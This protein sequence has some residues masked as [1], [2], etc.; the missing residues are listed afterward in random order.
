MEQLLEEG[1]PYAEWQLACT[2]LNKVPF[3]VNDAEE[4]FALI[5]SAGSGVHTITSF[6]ARYQDVAPELVL[7][8]LRARFNLVAEAED[9]GVDLKTTN[10]NIY[11]KMLTG[12]LTPEDFSIF[13]AFVDAED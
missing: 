2:A 5:R 8:S 9:C 3:T 4:G 6:A 11:R 10:P 13:P 1:A 12:P 7:A